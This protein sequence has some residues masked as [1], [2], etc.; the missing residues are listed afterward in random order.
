MSSFLHTSGTFKSVI[1]DTIIDD[2]NWNAEYDGVN[3]DVIANNKNK[4]IFLKLDNNDIEQL[5][6]IQSYPQSM[7]KNLKYSLK[8]K[9]MFTPIYIED[10]KS[11]YVKKKRCAKGTR[12][13]KKSGLCESKIKSRSSTPYRVKSIKTRKIKDKTPDILKTIY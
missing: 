11:S 2:I 6:K 4:Q 7:E 8:N 3:L 12:R 9:D 10:N 1:N 13:N 5:L